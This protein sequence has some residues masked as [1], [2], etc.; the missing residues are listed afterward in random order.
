MQT[1]D[2]P[3][4][5]CH[6][7]DLLQKEI[8]LAAGA[9]AHCARCDAVLYR[10]SSREPEWILA[11]TVAAGIMFFIANFFPIV[12][13]ELQGNRTTTTLLG[14]VYALAAQGRVMVAFMVLVTTIVIPAIEIFVL[15]FLLF[16][17]RTGRLLPGMAILLRWL[18]GL[19]PWN[20]AEVFLL[21]VL[22]SLVKLVQM[23]AIEPGVALWSFAGMVLL[24][25]AA[26]ASFSPRDFWRTLDRTDGAAG[27]RNRPINDDTLGYRDLPP[28]DRQ[29][30]DTVV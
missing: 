17:L 8:D 12:A 11:L 14:M 19:H 5:A 26:Y 15:S 24:L 10:R 22:V 9:A 16:S 4:I 21:G 27:R 1:E 23:A 18:E 29:D 30:M 7:C 20:M 6:D 2:R 3:L 25:C 28:T 13:L